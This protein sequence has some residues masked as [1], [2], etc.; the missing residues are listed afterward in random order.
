MALTGEVESTSTSLTSHT[1]YDSSTIMISVSAPWRLCGKLL[2]M[3]SL[4]LRKSNAFMTV[5]L[6]ILPLFPIGTLVIQ[7]IITLASVVT[8]RTGLVGTTHFATESYEMGR[9]ITQLQQE[10]GLMTYYL[11]GQRT[12]EQSA[13][14]LERL[15]DT[16]YL[17]DQMILDI[18]NW[19]TDKENQFMF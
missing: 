6:L 13:Q 7:N 18:S 8:L 10:R 3:D 9:C 12:N 19:E 5:G 16:F 4:E 2:C 14:I 11:S 1:V 17:T 15:K